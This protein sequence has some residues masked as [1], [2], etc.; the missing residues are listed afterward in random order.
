MTDL[1]IPFLRDLDLLT[2]C[3]LIHGTGKV[4]LK[5]QEIIE[6]TKQEIWVMTDQPFPFGKPK[7]DVRYIIPPEMTKFKPEVKDINRSTMVRVLSKISLSILI[8]DQE[9]AMIFFPDHKGNPDYNSGFF[10]KKDNPTG[11]EF[12]KRIWNHFWENGEQ[13]P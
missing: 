6:V 10:T 3:E 12:I 5:L 7:L 9:V 11:L 4:M 13:F 8:L 1:P 2:E